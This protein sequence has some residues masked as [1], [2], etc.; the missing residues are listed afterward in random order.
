MFVRIPSNSLLSR[1]I[2]FF[3]SCIT[4]QWL[5]PFLKNRKFS[6]T[7]QQTILLST[8]SILALKKYPYVT[9]PF[10]KTISLTDWK[11]YLWRE[12]G[13]IPPA[14]PTKRGEAELYHGR[15]RDNCARPISPARTR[16][17][18]DALI[19]LIPVIEAT[20]FECVQPS[21]ATEG[22]RFFTENYFFLR[23]SPPRGTWMNFA[24]KRLLLTQQLE[25]DNKFKIFV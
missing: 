6:Q 19:K 3:S 2:E 20:S 17:L 23:D 11:S 15:K 1:K 12:E 7:P 5:S 16:Q 18:R 10:Q 4:V 9:A 24:K 8:I 25:R 22:T 13:G 14:Y 21:R